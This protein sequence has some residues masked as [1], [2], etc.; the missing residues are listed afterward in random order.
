MHICFN[1]V[2]DGNIRIFL[3]TKLRYVYF[4]CRKSDTFPGYL[5]WIYEAMI[6]LTLVY[7]DLVLFMMIVLI[8]IHELSSSS[9]IST[10]LPPL[11]TNQR[12][13]QRH[14]MG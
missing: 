9:L 4:N 12:Q 6:L 5:E 14:L 2:E 3:I 7:H 10:S 1:V 13:I 8:F 11:R